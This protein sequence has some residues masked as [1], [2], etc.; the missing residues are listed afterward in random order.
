MP[1]ASDTLGILY[2]NLLDAGC[3]EQMIEKCMDYARNNE[4][5]K[6]KPCLADCKKSLLGQVRTNQK[7]IDCLDFLTY[8]IQKEHKQEDEL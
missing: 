5:E 7:Q 1:E 4:W 8:R 3:N 6:I 2:Q